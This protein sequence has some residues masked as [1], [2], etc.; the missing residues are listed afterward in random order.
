MTGKWSID[1]IRG[2]SMKE[3]HTIFTPDGSTEKQYLNA[4]WYPSYN[5]TLKGARNVDGQPYISCTPAKDVSGPKN[6]TIIVGDQI[7]S[8]ATN[9]RLCADP[10]SYSDR[11]QKRPI[12]Y[13]EAIGI[14]NDLSAASATST[15]D[16]SPAATGNAAISPASPA[17]PD[18]DSPAAAAPNT[19]SITI[20]ITTSAIS[21][22]IT[23]IIK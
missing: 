11:R 3:C 15:I 18:P 6:V 10:I 14:D 12:D 16:L 9:Y 2:A 7:D 13:C 21:S 20:T 4:R 22:P 8:C 23:K 19:N 5:Y 1:S 17:S